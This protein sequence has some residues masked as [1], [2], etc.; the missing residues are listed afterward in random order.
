[1]S[2]WQRVWQKTRDWAVVVALFGLSL[3]LYV[4]TLA[5]SVA[6]IF[7][8]SLEFQLVCYQ[9]GIAH[10]TGYPL[11]TLLGKAFTLLPW[12]DVAFRVNLMSALFAALTVAWLYPTALLLTDRRLPAIVPPLA[13][14]LSPVFWSQATI[15]EVYTLNALFVVLMLYVLLRWPQHS[16]PRYPL[17]FAFV[18]GLSLTHHR[19]MI[20]LLP[21]A[22][23]FLWLTQRSLFSRAALLGADPSARWYARPGVR[24][25]AAFA[26]PLL[27][28][29]Y[30]PIRGMYI[31]SLDGTYRNTLAGFI[32]Q[33]TASGFN[34]FFTGNPLHQSR[35]G[36]F[37][38]DLWLR[39]F[40]PLGLGLGLI[41]LAGSWRR[42][43][44]AALLAV[45]FATYGI[46][47]LLYRVADIEVFCIPLFIVW[48]LWIGLGLE[49]L[50]TLSARLWRRAFGRRHAGARPAYGLALALICVAQPALVAGA[51]WDAL[52]RSQQWAVHDYGVDMLS[53]PLEEGA[54][55]VGILGEMTLLRYFQQTEGRR[56]DVRT[57]A[58]DREP[59]RLAA[60]RQAVAEGR[61][62]YVTR[63]LSGLAEAYSLS[64]VGPLVRVHPA[65]VTAPPSPRYPLTASPTGWLRLLGYDAA[66]LAP[67]WQTTVR[68]T[69]YWQ[70]TAP[71]GADHK[72]SARLYDAQGHLLG[73]SDRVPVHDTYPTRLWRPGEAIA[74]VYDIPILPGAPP[75]Q[76]PLLVI[77]YDPATGAEVGRAEL[78]TLDFPGAPA[79]PPGHA[80]AVGRTLGAD[81]GGLRLV[82]YD[83]LLEGAVLGPGDAVPLT[84]LWQA[85]RPLAGDFRLALWFV[86]EGGQA[87]GQGGWPV[88]GAHPATTW[89]AGQLRRDWPEFAV[90]ATLPAGRYRLLLRVEH[91]GRP[92]AWSRWGVPR[93]REVE[94]GVVEID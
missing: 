82:G 93:G 12:G 45:A 29:L 83:P 21:A 90:P 89:G 51:N 73:Q 18:Y 48:A 75:G 68:L 20:L 6:T 91:D 58:A 54:T 59:E 33:I 3:G 76:H 44:R 2:T 62:V 39:Q 24:L 84:L 10:P 71:P 22:L 52:D 42:P 88:G 61:P 17:L 30:I 7:D 15:A 49:A 47:V 14:A 16:T 56:P 23:V 53:Q 63:P 5:P 72:I 38:F 11:Y 78:G 74:D 40:G 55:V 27:L 34:V 85:R 66:V 94:V 60:V 87:V 41:G 13:L 65:P 92:L 19:T 36:A 77:V 8:D 64:A 70:V 43:K 28:Y 26:L 57:V 80:L 1:M 37:Y 79:R 46:F 31:T 50:L 9:P 35:D 81:F 25:A 4:R 86:G 69:L 32:H 67:H